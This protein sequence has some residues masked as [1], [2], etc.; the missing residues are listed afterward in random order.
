MH[1]LYLYSPSDFVYGLPDE[2][3][4][5]ASGY[6]PYYLQLAPGATPTVIAVSDPGVNFNEVDANQVLAEDVTIDG[7][8]YPA[9]TTVNAAYDLL[10]SYNGHKVTSLHFGGDGYQQGPVQGLVSTVELQPDYVYRFDQERTSHLQFNPYDGYVSCYA[11]G[12]LIE[13]RDGQKPVETLQAGDEVMTANGYRP[14]RLL[15]NRHVGADELAANTK[16]RPIR[17]NAGALGN[18]LPKRDLS[19]SPQHRMLVSSPIVKRMFDVDEVLVPATKLA[20]LPGI[21]RDDTVAEVTYY[22]LVLDQHEVIYAEGAPSE[23]FLLGP[24][25]MQSLTNAA[26]EEIF[27]LFPEL[28]AADRLPD[29]ARMVPAPRLQKRLMQR[30]EKNAKPVL[31]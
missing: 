31:A 16:L 25:G 7:V 20:I 19:V 6:P 17:I 30:H 11:T 28:A 1:Y 14:V 5:A 9:G 2:S 21:A 29:T 13:T 23:T 15:L 4:S 12:T 18:G 26:L 8:T 27:T 22:H 3:G 10:N 24:Q